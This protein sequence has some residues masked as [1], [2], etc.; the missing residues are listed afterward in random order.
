MLEAPFYWFE[1]TLIPVPNGRAIT[2]DL[3]LDYRRAAAQRLALTA[4]AGQARLITI[5]APFL[6][7]RPVRE[8]CREATPE[9]SEGDG[10]HVRKERA[11]EGSA[12]SGAIVRQ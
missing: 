10:G 6:A 7:T 9:G 11:G 8:R 12:Q 3:S 2:S 5:I 1:D 4:R